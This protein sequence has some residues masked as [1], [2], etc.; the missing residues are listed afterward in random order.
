MPRARALA[1]PLVLVTAAALLAGCG[2]SEVVPEASASSTG[3]GATA[4]PLTLQNC[5]REITVDKAPSRVVSLDQDSTEILLSLGLQDR[6][7]GTASWTDPVLD[8]LA[9]ANAAVPRLSDNAPSYESFSAPTPTSSPPR[10]AATSPRAA[11]RPVTASPRPA[12]RRT[13]LPP[14]A[15]AT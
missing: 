8:T 4:Y 6:M 10:S 5:G 15:T 14:I 13:S 12:S 9:D 2:A 1:F 11:S 3:E 7:V